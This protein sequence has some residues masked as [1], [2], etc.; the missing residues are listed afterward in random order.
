MIAIKR[1]CYLK[2]EEI[3]KNTCCKRFLFSIKRTEKEDFPV[4]ERR[5]YASEKEDGGRNWG[6]MNLFFFPRIRALPSMKNAR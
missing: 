5:K 4:A 6:K 1:L 2:D 3:G